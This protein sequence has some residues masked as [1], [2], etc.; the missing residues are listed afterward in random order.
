[1]KTWECPVCH[2]LWRV[3][4]NP[5]GICNNHVGKL[6]WCCLLKTDF[7]KGESMHQCHVPCRPSLYFDVDVYYDE[8]WGRI[9]PGWVLGLLGNG[10]GIIK[11]FEGGTA[12]ECK[13][14]IISIVS[15]FKLLDEALKKGLIDDFWGGDHPSR[16]EL[17]RL[18]NKS[19]C[20]MT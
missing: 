1:M 7:E 10:Q 11:G 12:E 9:R 14:A 17:S 13:K 16:A 4:Y 8:S 15:G 19:N 5:N 18:L 6:D 2:S 20:A 3:Y